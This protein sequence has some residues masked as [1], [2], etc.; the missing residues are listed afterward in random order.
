[1]VNDDC[2]LISSLVTVEW[3]VIFIHFFSCLRKFFIPIISHKEGHDIAISKKHLFV[4]F[5]KQGFEG[6]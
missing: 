3:N 2:I 5:A 6:Q 4:S 1:M